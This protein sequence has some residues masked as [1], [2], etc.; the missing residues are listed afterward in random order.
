MPSR[1]TANRD[2]PHWE[3]IAALNEQNTI[4]LPAS[5]VFRKERVSVSFVHVQS[6]VMGMSWHH[7]RGSFSSES[8]MHLPKVQGVNPY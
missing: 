5:C 6:R 7:L 3:A 4:L 2:I 1:W 8:L